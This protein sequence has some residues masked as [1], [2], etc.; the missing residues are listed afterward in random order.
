MHKEPGGP[1][2]TVATTND[3]A[4]LIRVKLAQPN[5]VISPQVLGGELIAMLLSDEEVTPD[6]VMKHVLQCQRCTDT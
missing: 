1:A 2:R 6:F 4:N 3:A 5:L